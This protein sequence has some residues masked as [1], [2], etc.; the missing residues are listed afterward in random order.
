MQDRQKNRVGDLLGEIY[1][2]LESL[3]QDFTVQAQRTYYG[4]TEI[5]YEMI[6]QWIR[7]LRHAA[8]RVNE[9]LKEIDREK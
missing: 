9:A 7:E 8:S 5:D 6:G 4:T 1:L 3:A 2:S